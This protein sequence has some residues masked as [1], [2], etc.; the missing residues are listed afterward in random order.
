MST[1]R[2][3]KLLAPRAVALIGA[4]PR[5]NSVGRMVLKNLRDG[6]LC[7]GAITWSIRAMSEIEG[8]A[9]VKTVEDLPSAP[10]LVVVAAPPPAVPQIV[11][12]AG[13]KG[14][15]APRSSSR[16]GSATG[17]DRSPTA[18]QQAARA[19]GPAA[20]R[21]QLPR[22]AGARAPSS[23]PASPPAC[24]AAATSR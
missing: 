12:A 20:R 1:Y 7:T 13:E 8:I 10:D 21:A 2:L 11:A 24:R 4:S 6:R 3:D 23:M 15:A 14:V 16:R 5:P 17:R 18:A 22:G 19:H 9:A